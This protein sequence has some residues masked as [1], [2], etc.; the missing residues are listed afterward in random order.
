M[1]NKIIVPNS[2]RLPTLRVLQAGH[3]ILEVAYK[4]YQITNENGYFKL[5]ITD[6]E[7]KST[8]LCFSFTDCAITFLEAG[9]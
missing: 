7:D 3:R 2:F 9:Q 8:E 1:E 4:S 5:V 6:G